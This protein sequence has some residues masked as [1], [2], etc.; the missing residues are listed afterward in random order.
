MM[1]SKNGLPLG[2]RPTN[3]NIELEEAEIKGLG[4]YLVQSQ[5][6]FLTRQFALEVGNKIIKQY[7]QQGGK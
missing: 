4:V 1:G 3:Y 7:K 2:G 5:G 6:D